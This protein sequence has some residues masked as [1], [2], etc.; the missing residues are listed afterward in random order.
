DAVLRL[1]QFSSFGDRNAWQGRRH[2][3]QRAFIEV[4]HELGAELTRW[5]HTDGQRRNR[6]DNGEGFRLQHA[7]H[8]R[9]VDP[10]EELLIGFRCSGMI[11]P[12][13]K[14]TISAGTKVTDRSAAA[15][16][17]KVLVKASGPNSRP[18]CDSSVKIGRNETVMIKRLKNS[19]GPTSL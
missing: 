14:I 15:A 19:A 11:L 1:Q 12:R 6:D 13:T 4:R 2:I 7:A 8:D 17:E 10:D 9:P 3:E 18:S 5:P 16:I